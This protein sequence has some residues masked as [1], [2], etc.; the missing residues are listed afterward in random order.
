MVYTV[1]ATLKK[2]HDF[3]KTVILMPY[4]LRI[5]TMCYEMWIPVVGAGVQQNRGEHTQGA[6]RPILRPEVR[7]RVSHR[8]EGKCLETMAV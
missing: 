5:I 8:W 4:P 2:N 3:Q 7:G 1:R 6:V